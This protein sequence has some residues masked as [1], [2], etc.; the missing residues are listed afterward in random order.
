[1]IKKLY[2]PPK[3]SI[4][5]YQVNIFYD[6]K[7]ILKMSKFCVPPDDAFANEDV[8]KRYGCVTDIPTPIGNRQEFDSMLVEAINK[9]KTT[10]R[11]LS[12]LLIKFN[13]LEKP[14]RCQEQLSNTDCHRRIAT[15]LNKT[16]KRSGDL[17]TQ[18]DDCTFACI[19]SDTDPAGAAEMA[20]KFRRKILNTAF[21]HATT[22]QICYYTV[23]IG[24]VTAI[25]TDDISYEILIKK[26][27]Q[28]L[29]AADAMGQN[30]IVIN[31]N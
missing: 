30:Q 15:I 17:V 9:A 31:I 2:I 11:Y 28:A 6:Q 13:T 27:T 10:V 8:S 5:Y 4:K 14:T 24:V 20:E 21:F 18:W 19:L 22:P 29:S 23:S 3:S 1:M 12:I 7:G 16:L 26:V 25:L